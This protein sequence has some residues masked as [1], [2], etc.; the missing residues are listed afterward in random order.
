MDIRVNIG[1]A[2]GRF[3]QLIAAAKRGEDVIIARAGKP[4][5][6]LVAIGPDAAKKER[7]A[8]RRAFV[9]SMKS[10]PDLDAPADSYVRF[11]VA[12][13]GGPADEPNGDGRGAQY[14]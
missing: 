5:V 1:E 11:F 4:E 14:R 10:S 2:K 3:S 12:A 13:A 7:A 9:G 8:R 6:R